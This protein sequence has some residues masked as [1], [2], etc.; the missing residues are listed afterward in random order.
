[1][2]EKKTLKEALK[3]HYQQTQLSEEQRS[4]LNHLQRSYQPEQ[5]VDKSSQ[6]S[7]DQGKKRA[8]GLA[9]AL[10]GTLI[11][12]FVSGHLLSKYQYQKQLQ[13]LEQ[14][15]SEVASVYNTNDLVRD[16]A[17][18]IIFNHR[19]L[20]P[21]E[22]KTDRF[23]ELVK[24]FSMLD[25]RPYLSHY[26][27]PN[28]QLIG[29]RYCSIGSLNAVQIRYKNQQDEVTTLY[30]TA[31]S[32]ET[33]SGLPDIEKGE[34]AITHYLNGY[35]VTLWVEMGIVMATVTSPD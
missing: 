16:I 27:T 4:G 19:K 30:Q 11:I 12:G 1:M 32:P 22:I 6:R 21:L 23:E 31:Y 25:F 17:E 35:Q 3:A 28:G 18:E 24:Y 20:K 7:D 9:A 10:F 8:F 15:T 5:P 26:F 34:Q 13:T 33:F 14:H 29:G 2:T